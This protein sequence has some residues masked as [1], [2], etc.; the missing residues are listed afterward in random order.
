MDAISP[1]TKVPVM[2]NR[3]VWIVRTQEGLKR[4][5]RV[6]KT[7]GSWR[8][9]SKCADEEGWTYYEDPLMADLEEFREVLFRKYQRRRAA[10]ED[11]VWAE[12]E[13]VRRR[14]LLRDFEK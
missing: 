1:Q 6:I 9:Q 10:Y 7:G 4:E 8:F 11:V 13:L 3:H 14:E 2:H 5:V 12:Q